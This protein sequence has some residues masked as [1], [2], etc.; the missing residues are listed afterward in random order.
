VG[1][2]VDVF[3]DRVRILFTGL[4]SLAVLRGEL[5]IPYSSIE[6]VEVGLD[7]LPSVWAWR[8]GVSLPF[9]DRRQG[10]FWMAGVTRSF[11]LNVE[12]RLFLDIRDRA[13]SVVL[14]LKPGNEYDVVAFD[15]SRPD[16]LAARIRRRLSR[17]RS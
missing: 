9:S 17:R 5:S 15:D 11:D 6:E 1:R 16:E 3:D 12:Q 7:E 14:R 4:D 10:R 8:L 13:H 2:Y